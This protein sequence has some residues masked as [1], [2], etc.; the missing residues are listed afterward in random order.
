MRTGAM[1]DVKTSKSQRFW[2]FWLS[3][4]IRQEFVLYKNSTKSSCFVKQTLFK[5]NSGQFFRGK[6]ST[7]IVGSTLS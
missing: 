6:P 5:V 2:T 1:K 4:P 7:L 3:E